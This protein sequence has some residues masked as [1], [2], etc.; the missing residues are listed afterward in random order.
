MARTRGSPAVAGATTSTST[1]SRIGRVCPRESVRAP[2][3][4]IARASRLPRNPAPPVMTTRIRACSRYVRKC[5]ASRRA[6]REARTMAGRSPPIATTRMARSNR[7]ERA[8]RESM[9]PRKDAGIARQAPRL[10]RHATRRTADIARTGP[11]VPV[12]RP[13]RS[14]ARAFPRARRRACARAL[15]PSRAARARCRT[16]AA[17]RGPPRRATRPPRAP[18]RRPLRSAPV[19][20]ALHRHVDEP[21]RKQRDGRGRFASV[22]FCSIS[23]RSTASAATIASPVVCLSRQM[24]WP[25]FSPPSCQ[26]R[27]SSCSST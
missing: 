15:R 21:L 14:H 2:R 24:R 20:A 9:L 3:S 6:M 1:S 16:A 12:R 5:V 23:A 4:R 18:R 13:P 10:A 17:A 11:R 8:R 22:V 27:S 26:P 7:R 25:E 19:P